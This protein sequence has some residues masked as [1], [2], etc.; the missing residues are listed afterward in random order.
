MR[1]EP[2]IIDLVGTLTEATTKATEEVTTFY[3][4]I[5]R[6]VPTDHHH[7]TNSFRKLAEKNWLAMKKFFGFKI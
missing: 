6:G 1:V 4:R 5:A 7:I 2:K 3:S